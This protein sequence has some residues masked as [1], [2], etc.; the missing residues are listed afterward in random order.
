VKIEKTLAP[1]CEFIDDDI[2]F[3]HR[4]EVLWR[5]AKESN[6]SEVGEV[7]HVSGAA[8]DADEIVAQPH[9]QQSRFKV[10]FVDQRMNLKI[11]PLLNILKCF[12]L[13]VTLSDKN[14]VKF[15]EPVDLFDRINPLIVVPQFH[16]PPG[17]GMNNDSLSIPR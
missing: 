14:E 16:M 12:R 7:C 6:T 17:P 11:E 10:D 1:A 3:V 5:R 2:R 4:H 8:I 9:G 13:Q 15:P